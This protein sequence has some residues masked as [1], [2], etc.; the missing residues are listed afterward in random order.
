LARATEYACL[1]MYF[2]RG[3]FLIWIRLSFCDDMLV[4]FLRISSLAPRL[5]SMSRIERFFCVGRSPSKR[6]S[7]WHW[8]MLK[9][10]SRMYDEKGSVTEIHIR[11][12][13]I[14]DDFLGGYHVGTLHIQGPCLEFGK[15]VI[16]FKMASEVPKPTPT[17]M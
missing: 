15:F 17:V 6:Q 10:M 5:W 14:S 12:C 1:W 11:F 8:Q 2:Q 4:G 13:K 16:T 9:L 3:Q 7:L